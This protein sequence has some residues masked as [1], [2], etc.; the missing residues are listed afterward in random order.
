M[1]EEKKG[2]V[3]FEGLGLA[4]SIGGRHPLGDVGALLVDPAPW[5]WP[6]THSDALQD[7]VPSVPLLKSWQSF[8]VIYAI[9]V[10]L[11]V[12]CAIHLPV[13][14]VGHTLT[15]PLAPCSATAPCILLAVL[16]TDYLLLAAT[17]YS[18]QKATKEEK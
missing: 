2:C 5:P 1:V 18:R 3:C 6:R 7:C 11:A 12:T 17:G 15:C 14:L 9:L 8:K 13:V 10:V 16:V 4:N